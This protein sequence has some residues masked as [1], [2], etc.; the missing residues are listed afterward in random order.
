MPSRITRN[1]NSLTTKIMTNLHK[2]NRD[3]FCRFGVIRLRLMPSPNRAKF[4]QIGLTKNNLMITTTKPKIIGRTNNTIN[5]RSKCRK[6]SSIMS[7]PPK[8]IT[9]ISKS[10]RLRTSTLI[11]SRQARDYGQ[12]WP[13]LLAE[14]AMKIK[15]SLKLMLR[16]SKNQD[17]MKINRDFSAEYSVVSVCQTTTSSHRRIL[18]LRLKLIQSQMTTQHPNKPKRKKVASN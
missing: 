8:K 6:I 15:K 9:I 11:R 2:S 4:L 14:A 12:K 16:K 1:S 17:M 5:T 7:K 3:K 10:T 13:R 18:L